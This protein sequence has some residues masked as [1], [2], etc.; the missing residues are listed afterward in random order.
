MLKLTV[1]MAVNKAARKIW[2][3]FSERRETAEKTPRTPPN[4]PRA[5]QDGY[6]K[7][8][9]GEG[10]R[11]GGRRLG[12]CP[13]RAANAS[14]SL[15]RSGS[16]F[17]G[18]QELGRGLLLRLWPDDAEVFPQPSQRLV[19]ELLGWRYIMLLGDRLRS[20]AQVMLDK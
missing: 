10:R 12:D 20:M 2:K 9:N 14:G 1:K 8:R 17:A 5:G 16:A 6:S 11:A 3:I 15:S 18:S 19:K 4:R 7:P 13:E